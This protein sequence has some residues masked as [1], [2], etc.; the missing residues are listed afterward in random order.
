LTHTDRLRVAVATPLTEELCAL[1]ERL[2]PRVEMVRDQSLLPPMRWAGDFQGDPAFR[3]TPEQQAAFEALLDSADVLYGIPDVEPTALARAVRA[4]PRL[5]WVQTMA[6]GGGAQVKAAE[7]APDEL[8]RV[9][10]TTS[11]GA[12]A[13][14]LAEFA[15]FGLMA[16][17]KHLPRL[18]A[19]RSERLWSARW[20]M[21]QLS[22]QTILV[23]GL[24][25]IGLEVARKVSALGARVIGVH[26]RQLDAPGVERIVGPE[27]LAEVAPT[28]D[29]V[30]VTLPGTE[31]TFQLLD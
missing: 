27:Q 14:P 6:A 7:L 12:H 30:V 9:T 24:G 16:G 17:A 1:V 26:R 8:E 15:V 3:R 2:E 21:G 22:E 5:R 25:H 11:A 31:A 13:G 10:F 20:A 29:G 28:V 19:Q 23:V 4:N 18:I